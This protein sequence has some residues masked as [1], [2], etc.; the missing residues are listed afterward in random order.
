MYAFE[1][2]FQAGFERKL[3]DPPQ[4]MPSREECADA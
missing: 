1:T 3:A 2:Q 4:K